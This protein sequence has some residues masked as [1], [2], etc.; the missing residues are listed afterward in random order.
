MPVRIETHPLTPEWPLQY[1]WNEHVDIGSAGRDMHASY[2]I[3]V[4]LTGEEERHYADVVL[5]LRPGDVWLTAPW[6][7][8]GWR[9]LKPETQEV[10]LQFRPDFLARSGSEAAFWPS[11]FA[12]PPADRPLAGDDDDRS[13]ILAILDELRGEIRA[14]RPGWPTAARLGVLNLLLVLWR[15]WERPWA[16]PRGRRRPT[17]S[18]VA[19]AV[20]LVAASPTR[21]VPLAE[22]AAVCRASPSQFAAVFRDT[23][24]VSFGRYCS[25]SRLDHVSHLLAATDTPIEAIAQEAGFADASHLHR[26]FLDVYGATPGEYRDNSGARRSPESSYR[27]VELITPLDYLTWEAGPGRLGI[28]TTS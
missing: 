14:Q 4:L 18:L 1:A 21:R 3:G 20:T 24:G 17:A 5:A 8:H 27:P 2:E 23:M 26:A 10:V 25:I 19:P 15:K 7:P 22:A 13:H 28:A 16:P 9:P 12:A 6:E 11:L